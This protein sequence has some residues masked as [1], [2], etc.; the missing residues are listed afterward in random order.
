MAK[1]GVIV[2]VIFSFMLIVFITQKSF[3]A[4]TADHT[5]TPYSDTEFATWQHDLHRAEIITLGALPFVTLDVTLAYSLGGWAFSGFDNSQFVNPFAK[6][7]DEASFTEGEQIGIIL[8]SLGIC[9]GIGIT[10]FIVHQ[11]KRASLKKKLRTQRAG[12]IRIEKIQNS[13]EYTHITPPDDNQKIIDESVSTDATESLK[14]P[15]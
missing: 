14:N 3:S 1:C 15:N 9:L 6:T 8:V 5:P 11:V 10:D 7:S 4:D 2:K 12:N 13:E